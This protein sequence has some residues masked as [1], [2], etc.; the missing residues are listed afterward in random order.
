[1]E[2][3]EQLAKKERIK[4]KPAEI[5]FE[6]FIADSTKNGEVIRITLL[7]IEINGHKKQ[8]NVVVMDLNGMDIFLGHD[9]LVRYNSEVNWKEDTI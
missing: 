4:M 8:I 3:N 9:W 6:V 1:M 5:F 2:I 7:E